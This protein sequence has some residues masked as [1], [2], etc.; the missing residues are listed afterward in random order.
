MKKVKGKVKCTCKCPYCNKQVNIWSK[1]IIFLVEKLNDKDNHEL[2]CP[3]C[4]RIFLLED[5]YF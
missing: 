1:I 2:I 5:V 3:H 4:N